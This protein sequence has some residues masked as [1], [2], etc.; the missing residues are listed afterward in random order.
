MTKLLYRTAILAGILF[1]ALG[2][3][4]YAGWP[5]GVAA[6]K[7][8]NFSAAA[9]EFQQ[10]VDSQPDWPGGHMMLGRSQLKLNKNRDA[11]ASLQKAYE[12]SPSDAG[13]QLFLGEAYV[14]N[15]RYGDAVAF[16]SKINSASVP[17][18][19]QGVLA[20]L[21]A[22]ALVKSGQ[23]DRALA[24]YAKA[25]QANP[26]SA[27]LQFQ[28]GTT[29]YNVGNTKQ[30]V[31]ALAKA[32]QLDSND[33]SKQSAYA[34]ALNRLGRET[35]GAGKTGA[36]EKAARAAQVV[37]SAKP[38]YDNILLLGETQLGAK[39]Y[40]GAINSF[41]QAAGK[42]AS[43]WLP[44]F[45]LGQAYTAKGQ[46]GSA[47]SALRTALDRASAGDSQRRVWKQLA[48][49]YEKQ[50]KYGEAIAAYNS[51]GDSAGAERARV[52]QETNQYNQDV[53]QEA[54]E[55]E[56]MRAEQERIKKEL[57]ELGGGGR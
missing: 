15:G 10:V 35:P 3:A 24:E 56:A 36:Y 45:Y 31:D 6:F 53:D 42:S 30:A 16:L 28:Y 39:Q 22:V 7:A 19:M 23:S 13:I 27:D 14:A 49:V 29:A 4:A 48:F 11:L 5:E 43:E 1:V 46:Y 38:T 9:G 52:N 41:K 55:L 8:G 47:E 18:N 37:A 40:D 33:I 25:V 21:K 2:V 17:K 32:V 50:K 54:Q 20:Q 34:K 51:A 44:Q 26:S 57:E 12:L